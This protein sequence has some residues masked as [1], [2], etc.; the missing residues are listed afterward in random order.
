MTWLTISEYDHGYVPVSVFNQNTD[1][2]YTFG[3]FELFMHC[4]LVEVSLNTVRGA[5]VT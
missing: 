3:I 2:E 1:T 4:P 5:N